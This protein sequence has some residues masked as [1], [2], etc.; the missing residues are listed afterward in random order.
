MKS[1]ALYSWIA[2]YMFL[3]KVNFRCLYSISLSV[4]LSFEQARYQQ[5]HT[6]SFIAFYS[7]Y[8]NKKN[9]SIQWEPSCLN[10]V[11]P[12]LKS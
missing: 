7:I 12:A 1:L 3:L 2:L 4:E 5:V 9:V 10:K 6:V 8:F 11:K